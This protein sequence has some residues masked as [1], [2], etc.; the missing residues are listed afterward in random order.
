MKAFFAVIALALASSA[1]AAFTVC[2]GFS[3]DLVNG[4]MTLNPPPPLCV[5]QNVVATVTGDLIDDITDGATLDIV[6]KFGTI[7]VYND[8]HDLCS[9]LSSTSTPCPVAAATGSSV[10]ATVQV[11]P[12]APT[13]VSYS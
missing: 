13:G 12:N 10:V 8:P 4:A 2:S 5:G 7:T 9:L 3:G 6:G 1:N 11:L